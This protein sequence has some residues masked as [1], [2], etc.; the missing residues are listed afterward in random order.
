MLRI[1]ML[2]LST[3]KQDRF[4]ETMRDFYQSYRGKPA[5]TDDFRSV[6]ER[7]AGVPMDWVCDEWVKGT[8]IPTYHV[9]RTSQPAARGGHTIRRRAT[10]EHVPGDL[11]RVARVPA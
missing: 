3:M 10:Q 2:D 4:L 9:A 8:A 7:H 1:L 5:T 11:Q 6:V